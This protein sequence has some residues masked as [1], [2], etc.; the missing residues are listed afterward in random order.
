MWFNQWAGDHPASTSFLSLSV[1]VDTAPSPCACPPL[2]Q[3]I[4]AHWHA[5]WGCSPGHHCQCL[6][7]T[8]TSVP[9]FLNLIM[10]RR[11]QKLLS[12]YSALCPAGSW[13]FHGP[14]EVKVA[15]PLVRREG[16]SKAPT[17]L[18]ARTHTL[19]L[20][21][22]SQLNKTACTLLARSGQTEEDCSG[23]TSEPP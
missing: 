11:S 16:G 1:V 21:Q 20:S 23:R 13:Y 15:S 5:G 2:E 7:D 9:T 18:T 10:G 12:H 4:L 17:S 6:Y 22:M 19:Q 8:I 3:A 14:P